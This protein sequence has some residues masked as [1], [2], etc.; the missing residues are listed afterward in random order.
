MT[1]SEWYVLRNKQPMGPVSQAQ[2]RD[3]AAAGKLSPADKVLRAGTLRWVAAGQVNGL[4]S[5][6]PA[7]SPPQPARQSAAE[8][9]AAL[10]AI[11]LI[12]VLYV[13]VARRGAPG[14][15]GLLGLSLGVVGFLMML[16]TETLY[17]LRKRLPR[18]TIG[19]MSTWLQVH[20]FTGLVG[21]YLVLLH[22]A[23]KF[24]G[25]AGV[26]MLL[27]G[28]MVVSGVFGRYIYTAVPRTLD[29]VEVAVRDL[30]ERI[31]GTER[32]LQAL[33]IDLAGTPL[34]AEVPRSVWVLVLGRSLVRWR[35][36]RRWRRAL[37][38]LRAADGARAAALEK[39]LAERFR[40]QM[41]VSSLAATR[42]L[43]ALWHLVHV[44]LGIGLF[45]LAAL[46]IGGAL[47]YSTMLK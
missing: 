4:F 9:Y 11:S 6:G 39:L 35:Q 27:T 23:G 42:R 7:V 20:I 8:L 31:A 43:L 15:G 38:E 29:G 1:E 32:R 47:Y 5:D 40:L 12:T 22:T 28:V 14:P 36:R 37:R 45:T 26:L 2:L 21:S 41:Q 16:S 44:P 3:L 33:G 13:Y 25:L 17:S 46:H 10:I 34:A 19:R 24:N 18:F 30:E